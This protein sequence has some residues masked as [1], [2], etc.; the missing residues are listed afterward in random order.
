MTITEAQERV[1]KWAAQ[2][3]FV[4]K[5]YFFGS[6]VTGKQ[7]SSSDLDIAIEFDP[8]SNDRNCD[9]TWICEGQQ[10]AEELQ[11]RLPWRVQLE[12]HDP[13]GSTPTVSR[14]LEAGNIVV[15]ERVI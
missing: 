6:R 15:Y 1:R 11:E 10:W 8:I 9:T 3:P 12:Y 13:N 2:R 14:G 4:R 5:V 7:S